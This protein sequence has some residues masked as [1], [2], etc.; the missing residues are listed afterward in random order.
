MPRCFVTGCRSGYDS[1]RSADEKR[2]FF[3]PPTDDVRLQ[4]WQRAIPRLDKELSR[5]CAVCDLHFQEDDIVKD[6]V[7]KVHGDVVVIPRG[8]W[9]L[10]EDAVPRIFPNCPKYLSKPARKRK[11]PTVRTP[12]RPKR[13]K[14]KTDTDQ[15]AATPDFGVPNDSSA[16][17]E[18][19][20]TLENNTQ[21]FSE[22]SDIAAAG[23]R[24]QG[25]SLE[26]VGTTIVLYKL[27]MREEIPEIDR[28]VVVSK[29]LT[30]SVSAKGQ[31]VTSAVYSTGA[32]IEL[33]SCDDLKCLLSR[34]ERLNICEGCPAYNY[35]HVLSSSVAVKN[36]ET[37][38][39]KSCTVLCLTAVCQECSSLSKLF[40]RRRKTSNSLQS[41]STKVKSLRRRAIRA[42]IQREKLKKEIATVKKQLKNVT[43]E[44][45]ERALDILPAKQQL[46]FK[47][48][49]QV[50]KAKAKNGKRY[51]EEWLMTCLLL[52]ISSPKAYKLLS[53]MQ[54]LPLPTRARLRQIISGIP[55]RYGFNE[56]SLKSIQEHF[57]KKSHLQ[58]CGVLLL[59]EVKLKQSVAFNKTSY[60]M[61]GFVDYGDVTNVTTDQ[62]ADHALV[63]MFVPLFESWVQPIASFA[64]KGAAPGRILAQLL[65]SAVLQLH[66]HNA[67]VLVVV[68]D[69]A[70]NNRSMWTNLGIS[71]D[72]MSPCNSIEHPWEPSQKIFFICDV[73]HIVKCIR[74]HLKK[75]TYGMAGDHQINFAHYVA[76]YEAEKSKHTRV[77]PKLTKAHVAPDNLQKMSVRLA[78]Q[79][80]SRGTAIG[81]RIYREAGTE[82]LR[83]SEGTEVFTRLL[84]DLFDA[85]NIKLPERGIKRHSKEIQASSGSSSY[86]LM[87]IVCGYFTSFIQVIKDFL[88]M[89]NSTEK[90]SVEQGLKLFASQQTTQSLRVTLMS[91]LEVIEFLL[92]EG[93]HYVLT[94][95]LNQDPLERHFGLVRSFGGDESHPT[96]V[97]FTQ[98]FRLLS[99]YTPIKTAMRGSVQ[100][101]PGNVL[102][103]VQD[104]LRTT[105]E[106]QRTKHACLREF[107]EKK[108]LRIVCETSGESGEQIDDHSYFKGEVDDAIVYYMSGYVVYKFQKHT[109]CLLC[110]EDI[111]SAEPVVGSDAYLTTY[112]SFKEG[113]MKHP[114]AKM[115]SVMR[116]V[117]DVVSSTL[118][119]AGACETIFW[120]VLEELEKC[121]IARL[122]CSEHVTTFTCQILNF[123]IVT[124]MHFFSRDFNHKL[125]SKEKVAVANKKA[126]LL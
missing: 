93:A 104:T 116:V 125:E 39:R 79:L 99:L 106:V 108:L 20:V 30:L 109:A 50:A 124:R 111:S 27:A 120:K 92:D 59:D 113:C 26:V 9:A 83:G 56:V 32:G 43:E 53:D 35:P 119:E 1:T 13:K 42:T 55:C 2:H 54:V 31:L 19:S 7:H 105:R 70:G 25:W 10:K 41:K 78:T 46:A 33:K 87:L 15:E 80:F 24:I 72:M 89:L 121:S 71:G 51:T 107:I 122:G 11:A 64:T 66:K 84:N 118:D 75:H 112:R 68:S 76:L 73:P 37:W 114:T 3:K 94:A 115:L 60:K 45:M 77:V 21:L 103:S 86:V 49:F 28:A 47:N 98:I 57:Q 22:L 6:Y 16:G 101:V 67:S 110:L 90:N 91:T 52:Q 65:L 126:R 117:N 102:A 12:T 85:L 36:G 81:I 48:A 17:S 8:K 100:G 97:N 23:Q 63:F 82:G 69:G 34:I 38:H 96:V 123:V 74:N 14:D 58:R 18:N 40:S 5:S 88:E 29:R 61:D 95:K 44:R 62:L 4:E